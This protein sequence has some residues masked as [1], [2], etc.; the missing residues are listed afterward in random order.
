MYASSVIICIVSGSV[1]GMCFLPILFLT[2]IIFSA[3][4][5]SSSI[6]T[7]YTKILL[8]PVFAIPLVKCCRN[9]KKSPV[10]ST[11]LKFSGAVKETP[12]F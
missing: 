11:V 3:I 9:H 8:L 12:K 1:P 5:V 2:A 7:E 10:S 4:L 6:G